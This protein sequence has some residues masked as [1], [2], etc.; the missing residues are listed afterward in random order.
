MFVELIGGQVFV[1]KQLS[2][3][4]AGVGSLAVSIVVAD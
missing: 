2:Y 1:G 3:R 4:T